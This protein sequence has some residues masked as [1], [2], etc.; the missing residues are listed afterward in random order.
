MGYKLITEGGPGR[1]KKRRTAILIAMVT[2][3]VFIIWG[4]CFDGWNIC[5][6][7]YIPCGIAIA[8]V[9]MIGKYTRDKKEGNID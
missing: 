2:T 3:A 9:S 8:A 1:M 6:I 4:M 5:W 7:V